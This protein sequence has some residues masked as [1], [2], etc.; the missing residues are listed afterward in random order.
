MDGITSMSL[1]KRCISVHLKVESVIASVCHEIKECSVQ[2][3]AYLSSKVC[4][5]NRPKK[6]IIFRK[7]GKMEVTLK[8][9]DGDREVT[10]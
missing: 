9:L 3:L 6:V 10:E 7:I 5:Q 1:V 4:W 2:C 8:S